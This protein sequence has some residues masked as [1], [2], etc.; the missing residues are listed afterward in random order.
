M[1]TTL[2]LGRLRFEA[3]RS[4]GSLTV[5][6]HSACGPQQIEITPGEWRDLELTAALET[7]TAEIR[8]LDRDLAALRAKQAAFGEAAN[9]G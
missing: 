3:H 6:M 9:H 7:Q 5:V 2:N 1:V 8:R 4:S